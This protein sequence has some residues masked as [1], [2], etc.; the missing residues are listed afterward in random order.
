MESEEESME[1]TR[2]YGGDAKSEE[3]SILPLEKKRRMNTWA[4]NKKKPGS[5]FKTPVA[6]KQPEKIP[7]KGESSQKKPK[8]K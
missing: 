6:P 1:R 4:S 7:M 8:G 3:P 5:T 2:S